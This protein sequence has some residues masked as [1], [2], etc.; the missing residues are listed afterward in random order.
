M[1]AETPYTVDSLASWSDPYLLSTMVG[2]VESQVK[3]GNL[4]DA[5][6]TMKRRSDLLLSPWSLDRAVRVLM[7][8]GVI[9]SCSA[10]SSHSTSLTP[11]CVNGYWETVRAI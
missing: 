8:A 6:D 11:L 10:L 7:L 9:V 1:L 3:T 5:D 4:N 2:D